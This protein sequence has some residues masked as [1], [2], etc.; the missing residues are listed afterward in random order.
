MVLD[1]K[2][3]IKKISNGEGRYRLMVGL[4]PP[5]FTWRTNPSVIRG[6]FHCF[7]YSK[8]CLNS[9]EGFFVSRGKLKKILGLKGKN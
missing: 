3:G 8:N 6:G 1:R 4:A 2:V 9:C 7:V 5:F